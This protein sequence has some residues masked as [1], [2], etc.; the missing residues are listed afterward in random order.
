MIEPFKLDSTQQK[1]EYL[2]YLRAECY[3]IDKEI[4]RSKIHL[5]LAKNAC[6]RLIEEVKM[7]GFIYFCQTGKYK[8]D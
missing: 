3:A 8:N 1:K 7:D 4:E 2:S 5:I 6:T